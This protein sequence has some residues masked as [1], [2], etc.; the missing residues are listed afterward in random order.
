MSMI[1]EIPRWDE[2]DEIL[3]APTDAPAEDGASISEQDFDRIREEYED[4]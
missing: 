2:L 4:E 3:I 1:W